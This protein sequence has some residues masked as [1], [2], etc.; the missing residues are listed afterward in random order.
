MALLILVTPDS[1]LPAWHVLEL[2]H[3]FRYIELSIRIVSIAGMVVRGRRVRKRVAARI[4]MG[5]REHR[6]G[7]RHVLSGGHE[8]LHGGGV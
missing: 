4:E 1:R 3:R 2:I 5:R 6:V 8:G 7:G